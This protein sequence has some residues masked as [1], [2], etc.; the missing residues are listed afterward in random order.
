[1][2]Y[3]SFIELARK[4]YSTRNFTSKQVTKEDV[5]KIIDAGRL[6]PSSFNSQPW[7]FVVVQKEDLKFNIIKYLEE[8]ILNKDLEDKDVDMGLSFATASIFIFVYGDSR[9]KKFAPSHIATSDEIWNLRLYTT[10]ATSFQQMSL[11]ATS[12][13]LGTMWVSASHKKG[14]D[15]KIKDLLGIPK[16]L[17]L[18]ELMAL[19]YPDQE[20]KEKKLRSLEE[21]THFDDCGESDFRSNKELEEFFKKKD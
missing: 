8:A 3:D 21:V 16:E 9:I 5:H 14:V 6:A 20:N 4:R 12:L 10:L 13:D 1:M 2:N 11:A 7:E 15:E 17:V 18:F 19:G